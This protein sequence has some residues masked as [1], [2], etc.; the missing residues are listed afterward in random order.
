MSER[1]FH[2]CFLSVMSHCTSSDLHLTTVTGAASF[3]RTASYIYIYVAF[4]LKM[5]AG[6]LRCVII[7]ACKKHELGKQTA[8]RVAFIAAPLT[9]ADEHVN[10]A[11][12]EVNRRK[13]SNTQNTRPGFR[14]KFSADVTHAKYKP[15]SVSIWPAITLSAEDFHTR[16]P[17]CLLSV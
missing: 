1:E 6:L 17:L 15:V 16:P 8:P 14:S 10:G 2:S 13:R 4:N 3:P 7:S 12:C 5:R 11:P 9:E